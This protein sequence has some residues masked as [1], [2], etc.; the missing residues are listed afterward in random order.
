M[1]AKKEMMEEHAQ[2]DTVSV[3]QLCVQRKRESAR[4]EAPEDT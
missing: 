2:N 3:K 4:A 1:K